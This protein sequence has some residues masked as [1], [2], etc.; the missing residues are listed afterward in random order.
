MVITAVG[1]AALILRVIY[2]LWSAPDAL[3]VSDGLFHHLQANFFVD[4]RGFIDPFAYTFFH[5]SRASAA[6]P[7]LFTI[8]LATVSRFGG[9]TVRAHQ[10]TE[11]FLETGAVVAI[12][13]LGR[14]VAGERTGVIAAVLAAVYP[15]LWVNEGSVL[16]E[17]LY[18]PL[19]A[20]MLLGAYR[21]WHRPDRVTAAVLGLVVG[22]AAL[23]RGE[24]LLYVPLLIAPLVLVRCWSAHRQRVALLTVAVAAALL[25]LTPWTIRNLVTFKEPVLT[26][27]TF[28]A[29][30]AGANCPDTYYGRHTGGWSI[31]CARTSGTGDESQL[32]N[33]AR[34]RGVAYAR[35]HLGRLPVVT[36]VRV[37]RAWEIYPPAYSLRQ[38]WRE[39]FKLVGFL[40]IVPPALAGVVVLHRRRA[41]VLPLLVPVVG[42]T[43][44]VALTWGA[45]RFRL[46]ADIA[47]IVLA[48]VACDALLARR[49]S[50]NSMSQPRH[51]PERALS[52]TAPPTSDPSSTAWRPA[53][54]TPRPPSTE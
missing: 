4:G 6:H 32:W 21:F 12:G 37:A 42:V 31:D 38:P 41:P 28:S 3:P 2:V 45:P 14:E 40:V 36:A 23:C 20:L 39:W 50:A 30:I 5:Q 34:R 33:A 17:S 27:N 48:A 25:T 26:S 22:L 13:W 7:P 35:D 9:R 51:V 46:A 11:C 43:L 44:T 16:V 8:V 1:I 19:I 29:V 53:P 52:A 10:L 18:A 24:A 49:P 47:F 15:L 54:T